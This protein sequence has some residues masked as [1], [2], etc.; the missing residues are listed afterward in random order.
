MKDLQKIYCFAHQQIENSKNKHSK[1]KAMR[2]LLLISLLLSTGL[3]ISELCNLKLDNINLKN[4]TI[5]IL[6]KGKKVRLLYI[7]NDETLSLLEDYIAH[8][9][10]YL[11][12]SVKNDDHLKEQSVRL[13][14]KNISHS[15]Q[16]KKHITPHMFRHSFA[17][18]LLDNGV[19]I[20]Q[21]Q[22]LLGHSNINVTQIYTHVSQSKQVEILSEHNPLNQ[23]TP[24]LRT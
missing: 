16:L 9:S 5:Q 8:H 13:S 2:N 15:L 14:L 4:R 7:G 18:M 10:S 22:H 3:R 1:R 24:L 23:I 6:E 11:F 17:T 12:T 21:I 19:D 20:R